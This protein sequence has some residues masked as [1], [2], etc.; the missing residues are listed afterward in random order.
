MTQV[1]TKAD[2]RDRTKAVEKQVDKL[3]ADAIKHT[4][5]LK[6]IRE[7]MTRP[8]ITAGLGKVSADI[9]RE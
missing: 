9:V 7:I 6:K 2:M 8:K 4:E 5:A 1:V 3:L